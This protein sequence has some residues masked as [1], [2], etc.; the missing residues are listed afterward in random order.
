MIEMQEFNPEFEAALAKIESAIMEAM[1]LVYDDNPGIQWMPSAWAASVEA[2][3]YNDSGEKFRTFELL[4]PLS[5]SISA[6][7]GVV[8]ITRDAF[9]TNISECQLPEDNE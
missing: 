6:S 7:S 5:Q 4:V 9:L 2:V 8:D 1:T 3:G